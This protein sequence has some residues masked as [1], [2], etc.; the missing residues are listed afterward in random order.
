MT[1]IVACNL[2]PPF[3]KVLVTAGPFTVA[4]GSLESGLR[5]ALNLEG[6]IMLSKLAVPSK[7][8]LPGAFGKLLAETFRILEKLNNSRGLFSG[9]TDNN[10][11]DGNG[12]DKNTVHKTD[13]PA[14][15]TRFMERLDNLLLDLSADR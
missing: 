13:N 1:G 9:S 3:G 4:L 15:K 7:L 10:R 8:E 14:R 12:A 5:K 6:L 11:P 2:F